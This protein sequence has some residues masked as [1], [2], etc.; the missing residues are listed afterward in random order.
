MGPFTVQSFL[1]EISP[2]EVM[3]LFKFST[4]AEGSSWR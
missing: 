3:T 4:L 2:G 1:N